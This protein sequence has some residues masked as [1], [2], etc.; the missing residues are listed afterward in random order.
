MDVVPMPIFIDNEPGARPGALVVMAG[1]YVMSCEMLARPPGEVLDLARMMADAVKA[2]AGRLGALPAQIFVRHGS[3]ASVLNGLFEGTGTDVDFDPALAWVDDFSANFFGEDEDDGSLARPLTASPILWSGW[4]LPAEQVA[5]LFDAAAAFYR[6]APWRQLAERDI[7]GAEFP[8]GEVWCVSLIGH[9]GGKPAIALHRDFDDAV[10]CASG[11]PVR[12][13]A[14]RLVDSHYL[15]DFCNR[16]D[17]PRA[18]QREIAARNWTVAATDAYPALIS[19]NTPG[20][21]ITRADARAI[22]VL[23]RALARLAASGEVARLLAPNQDHDGFWTDPESGIQFRHPA[24]LVKKEL[25]ELIEEWERE[26]ER[27]RERERSELGTGINTGDPLQGLPPD[28]QEEIR[29]ALEPFIDG[30]G[31]PPPMEM[32]EGVVESVMGKLNTRPQ[33]ELGGLSP[34]QLYGLLWQDWKEE[35][36]P[37]VLDRTLPLAELSCSEL[38]CNARAF[39]AALE[40]EEGAGA[41]DA[42]NLNRAFVRTML[43]EGRWSGIHWEV[44]DLKSKAVNEQDFWPLHTLRVL[45]SMAGLI[46]K[47]KKRFATTKRGRDLLE[48][49][50]AGELYARLFRV[51][52]REMNLA[53]GDRHPMG[54]DLQRI[55]PF[56][57]FRLT[58]TAKDWTN[59]TALAPLVLLPEVRSAY[60]ENPY[61]TVASVLEHRVLDRLC[62]F[63]LAER[64][65][66]SAI[67]LSPEETPYRLTPLFDR[68]MA[69]RFPESGAG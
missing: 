55:L 28:I 52:F 58:A 35:D 42:G 46:R 44:F 30:P 11:P 41:T 68:F 67:V 21:G 40:R 39:L 19:V 60:P 20:G 9:E 54:D 49:E 63:G 2:V 45:L 18:M 62:D 23:L 15:I 27:G 3:I 66:K 16:D 38:L 14:S 10:L 4:G 37:L 31:E 32:L 24:D 6:A 47:H 50:R 1:E 48:E 34:D 57:L 64:D 36:A 25:D 17:L 29:A 8:G 53:Y 43:H 56:T 59:A 7:V 33:A 12:E 65:A 5:A 26:R 51:R 61:L 69:F 22:P 13:I